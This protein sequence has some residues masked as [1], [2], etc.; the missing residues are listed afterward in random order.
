MRSNRGQ[1]R[2][3]ELGGFR[4]SSAGGAALLAVKDPPWSSHQACAASAVQAFCGTL[5]VRRSATST[6]DVGRSAGFLSRHC[7]MS[8]SSAD[9]ISNSDR[10]L[11]GIGSSLTC[12][13]AVAMA[14]SAD[15]HWLSGE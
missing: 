1:N 13:R 5:A 9:G 8:A 15:E 3:A 12:A 7:R 4:L 14:V 11:G 2:R 10:R 6:A